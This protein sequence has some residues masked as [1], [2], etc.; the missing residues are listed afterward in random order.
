MKSI[1]RIFSKL[2]EEH[3]YWS[4]LVCF[5]ESIFRKNFNRESIHRWFNKLVDTDDYD[6]RDKKEIM[7]F[8]ESISKNA[9]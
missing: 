2:N 1:E 6:T 9:P 3:P 5:S 4:T 8:L 7:N